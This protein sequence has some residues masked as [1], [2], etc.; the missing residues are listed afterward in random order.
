MACVVNYMILFYMDVINI[1]CTNPVAGLSKPCIEIV[2]I[3]WCHINSLA[4]GKFECKFRHIIFKQILV[5]DD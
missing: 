4:T 1:P 3:A 2:F 5:I